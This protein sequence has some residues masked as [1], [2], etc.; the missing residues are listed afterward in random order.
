MAKSFLG[1]MPATLA[2]FG[3]AFALVLT[4]CGGNDSGSSGGAHFGDVLS[5]S[6]QV[7]TSDWDEDSGPVFNHFTLSQTVTSS[8]PG[9]TGG[10]TNGQLNFSI[11]RPD[12]AHLSVPAFLIEELEEI[13][14]QVNISNSTARAAVLFLETP[15][16]DL[17]RGYWRETETDTTWSWDEDDVIFVFVDQDVTLSAARRTFEEDWDDGDRFTFEARAFN[18]TLG[19]G[20]NALH[21][22]MELRDTA[23]T[24][25]DTF[26]L[27]RANPGMP[28]RWILGG[29]GGGGDGEEREPEPDFPPEVEPELPAAVQ[30]PFDRTD[31]RRAPRTRR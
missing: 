14:G 10:I 20:W 12:E 29:W 26:T 19:E 16:D 8:P 5:L 7:W 21:L 11:G 2:V 6:G 18:F 31:A 25:S 4:G 15:E 23:T 22:R 27:S 9:G 3:L 17:H 28:V 30:T 1:K 13:W 24:T